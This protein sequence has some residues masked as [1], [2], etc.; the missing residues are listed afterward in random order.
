VTEA[1]DRIGELLARHLPAIRAFVR[2]R[3][4]PA[5][6]ARESASDVVQSVCRELLEHSEFRFLGDAAL[7]AWL[8]TA[9][10]RKILEKD[11]FHRAAKRDLAREAAVAR[12]SSLDDAALLECYGHLA[13]PSRDLAAREQIA[14]F[15]AAFARL[16][17]RDRE[18]I[19]LARIAGMSHAEIAA[20]LGCSEESSRTGL[21]RALI[22]LSRF[23]GLAGEAE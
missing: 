18:L 7:R 14:A 22:R 19:T 5:V 6:A 13:T 20:Q 10:L 12:N 1:P 9:A 16:S 23:L 2:L 8:Y 21:R 11:R 4:G 17:E 3:A 15:E